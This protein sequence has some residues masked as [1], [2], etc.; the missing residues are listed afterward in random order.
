M[1]VREWLAGLFVEFGA[2]AS[3]TGGETTR[4]AQV[5]A[6]DPGYPYYGT[7]VTSPAGEWA[8]LAET[9]G[10]TVAQ[11]RTWSLRETVY[12]AEDAT[13]AVQSLVVSGA[14]ARTPLG[15]RISAD[16]VIHPVRSEV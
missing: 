7:I 10:A 2:M 15:G 12:R 16:T 9:G 11:L 3:R 5:L 8:R 1:P 14:V 13:K 6:V 4:L